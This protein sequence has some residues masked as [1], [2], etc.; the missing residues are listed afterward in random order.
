MTI[1]FR[2]I[3]IGKVLGF[4]VNHAD[5]AVN[6]V[7]ASKEL[8]TSGA[9]KKAAA[10]KIVSNAVDIADFSDEERALALLPQFAAL[11]DAMVEA[12]VQVLKTKQALRAALEQYRAERAQ[13]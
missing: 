5:Q 12:S 6:I 8:F 2:K 1:N 10:L 11:R 13:A 3:D 9:D 4:L 7:E